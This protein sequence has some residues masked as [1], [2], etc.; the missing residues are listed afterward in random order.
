MAQDYK[1]IRNLRMTLEMDADIIDRSEK[2]GK[3]ISFTMRR[4]MEEGIRRDAKRE[5][6]E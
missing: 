3:S 6:A 4:Y 5:L 1:A 2:A